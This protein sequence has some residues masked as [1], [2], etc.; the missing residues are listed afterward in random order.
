MRAHEGPLGLD[1]E[2]APCA[3]YARPRQP[4][5]F[6][7]DG[8]LSSRHAAEDTDLTGIDPYRAEIRTVQLF[9]GGASAYVFHGEALQH[10]LQSGWL[11]GKHLV[12]HSA[13]FEQA[14]LRHYYKEHPLLERRPGGRVECTEQASGL[15][16]G[17]GFG[18]ER[19]SLAGATEKILRLSPP[20]DLQT[21]D[22]AARRLSP[23]QIA[24]AAAD[25]VLA[26]QLWQKAA[27]ALQ[28][29]GRLDAYQVQHRAIAPVVDMRMRGLLID[30]QEHAMQARQWAENLAAARHEYLQ[31]MGAPPPATNTEVRAWLSSVL[32][33]EE[34]ARWP[35]TKTGLLTTNQD[36]LKR[37]GH[38]P[39]LRPV[40]S[41]LSHKKMLESFGESFTAYINPVTGRFHADY[42]LAGTKAG[43]FSCRTPNIQQLP[44]KRRAPEFRKCI[45]AAP[46]NVLVGGDWDQMELR[47]AAWISEDPVMTADFVAGRDMHRATAATLNKKPEK[48]V[49]D[50]ER[51]NAKPPN[52]G[53]IYGMGPRKLVAMAFADYNIELTLQDAERAL[54]GIGAAWRGFWKWRSKHHKQ[55]E[56]RGHIKIGCGRVVEQEWEYRNRLS[57]N[58]C[59]NLPIQ[60][61]C[62]DANLR[63][64]RM[65]YYRCIAGRVRGGLV[66]SIHDEL[67]LEA[68]EDDAAI[69]VAILE[70]AMV[71]AFMETFPG[72]PVT[73]LVKVKIGHSWADLK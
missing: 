5:L 9:A 27:P 14:F 44:N 26:W 6:N 53:A 50:D 52:F 51:T 4:V 20:K 72:A 45:I 13:G 55:C 65:V 15:L 22:W 49:T 21:S 43:R 61:A 23:G 16:I 73:N 24:Y 17:L 1:I 37:L 8:A 2:T 10:L 64:L 33:P 66:A 12:A 54:E 67:I 56:A 39:E 25:S 30:R 68:H 29:K 59:C 48:E 46:G 32:S 28:I 70:Q 3:A 38:R 35:K 62:A 42:R 69:A 57:F 60:G 41:I 7:K 71:A 58:Q 36:E 47:A 18:G 19:R 34:A 63:A 31:L 11:D 40:L